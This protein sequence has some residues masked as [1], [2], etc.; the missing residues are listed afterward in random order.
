M[1]KRWASNEY[2]YRRQTLLTVALVCLFVAV[3]IAVSIWL[4]GQAARP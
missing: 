3:M 2:R 1:M 4:G